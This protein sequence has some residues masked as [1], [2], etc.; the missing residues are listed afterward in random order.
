MSVA[1]LKILLMEDQYPILTEQQLNKL[2]TMYESINQ[3]CYMGCL[4]KAQAN[5]ITVGP[6]TIENDVNFWLQLANSFKEAYEE[7]LANQRGSSRSI[8]GKCIGRSDE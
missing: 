8:T 2:A 1:D 4:M 5:K 7:E 6:I 3:A